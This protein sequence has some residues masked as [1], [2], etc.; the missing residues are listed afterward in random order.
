MIFCRF[1]EFKVYSA[2][3]VGL[4]VLSLVSLSAYIITIQEMGCKRFPIRPG[5]V[6]YLSINLKINFQRYENVP[7]S[8]MGYHL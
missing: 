8:N 1:S 5:N 2:H 3:K 4:N 7:L 6:S